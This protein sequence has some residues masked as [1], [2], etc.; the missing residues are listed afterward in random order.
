MIVL[1]SCLLA[2]GGSL[3][4]INANESNNENVVEYL[5]SE[6]EIEKAREEALERELSNMVI[7]YENFKTI[8]TRVVQAKQVYTDYYRAKNQNGFVNFG[9]TGGSIYWVDDNGVDATISIGLSGYGVSVGFSFGSKATGVSAYAINC[10]PNT[11]CLLYV[12]RLV[13]AE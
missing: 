8:E 5:S 9:P 1:F 6:E 11:S 10:P 4:P 3:I 2:I 7:P 13:R 12:Q